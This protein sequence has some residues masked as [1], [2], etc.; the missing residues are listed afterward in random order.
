ME[1][2]AQSRGAGDDMIE[3]PNIPQEELMRLAERHEPE[4]S[5]S[6]PSFRKATCVVCESPMVVMAH[7]WLKY[8]DSQG[9]KWVKE[10]HLCR[11]CVQA[12]G[13]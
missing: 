3:L 10:L 11:E 13:K 9:Q 6:K 5:E 12:Y 7:Y 8:T 4:A 1:E 2:G